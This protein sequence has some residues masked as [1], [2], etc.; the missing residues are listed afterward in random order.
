MLQIKFLIS[1]ILS[2]SILCAEIGKDKGAYLKTPNS[3]QIQYRLGNSIGY[4]GYGWNE[5]KLS[6]LS[7]LAGYDGQIKRLIEFHFNNWG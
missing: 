2:F 4:Y 7:S 5:S 3:K 6:N 1:I